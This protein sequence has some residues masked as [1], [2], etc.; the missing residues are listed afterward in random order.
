MSKNLLC[1]ILFAV[2][3]MAAPA[4]AD[5]LTGLADVTVVDG[6][7]ISLRYQG[8]EYVVEEGDLTLGTTTRW[9]VD[10]GVE[11]LWPEGDPVPAATPTVSGTSNPK[12]G[13]V[14]SKAD[15]FLFTLNGATNISSIDGIDFQETIF[16]IPANTF[17]H[18]ERGGNDTGTWQAIRLDGSLGPAVSFSG[19]ANY[20]DTGVG[21]NGQN[22]FGVVFT[23]DVPVMGV[24][25]T[26]SGHDTFS[27]SVPTVIP[28]I[29]T[30]PIPADGALHEDIWVNLSWSPGRLAVS[31][32]LYLGDN[33]DDVDSGA[34]STFVGNQGETFYVAGFPGF[35]IPE[36]LIPGETYYW[37]VDEVND[38]EPNSPWKGDVWSFSIP[39]KTAYSPEPADGAEAVDLNADLS[40]T[41]GFGVKLHTVYF[42][43]NFDDVS[44][45]AGGLAQGTATYNPGTLELAK[46]YYWRV[47]EF[48]II[49][50][51]KGDVWSFT[52]EGAVEAVDPANGAVDVTQTPILTWAPGQGTSYE[53]Y[54]GADA[55]SLEL[56]GS[57]N[58]GSESY[59]AGNL[60]WNTTYYWRVDET[61]NTNA[62]SPWTGPLWSFTTANFLIVD[63]ME[64]YND[65]NE[66]EPGS[67]RIYLA[68]VDGFDNPSNG[69]LVGNDVPPF[70]E[71][72]IV[73]SGSQSMPFAYDNAVG[74]SEATLTLAS[75]R[76]WTVNGVSTLTIWYRGNTG[77][78]AENLYAAL[79]GN[80]VVNND[81]PNA[82][83]R[84]SWT[85]WDIDLQ[86][87]ADQGVNLS[88]VNSITLG[89]SSVTGGAGM[90][91]FDDI[92]LY[93]PA[94]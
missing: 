89:L 36:G 67:N 55:D 54:F 56:K 16:P 1:L 46:T 77:N 2:V 23:T 44:N 40:W 8:T 82:A 18:F 59:T 85:R 86:A 42:G 17:F 31:H 19:A 53:V 49:E 34:E 20:A 48:D 83:T 63:D 52:T 9:Y 7:I 91:H 4:G 93:A 88:N 50:T 21:V 26:A 28:I 35:A 5:T 39:P 65:I 79:N 37:R 70:A 57:G 90:M 3:V 22:A 76:D 94:P 68:W 27:I 25:I 87:F 47:D 11:V 72:N 32:D 74:K 14:G 62:N 66:G 60:E 24:R 30:K 45:A 58:L 71:Q 73:H 33:F 10:G 69:S 78:A 81:N 38:S 80:A 6:A 75:N 12:D 29:A 64:S 13:D 92:R 41:G 15:N 51:H 61:D 43:D 84:G